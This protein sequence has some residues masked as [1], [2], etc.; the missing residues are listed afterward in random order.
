MSS[1]P[2]PEKA[3]ASPRDRPPVRASGETMPVTLDAL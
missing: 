1:G 2:G 3:M